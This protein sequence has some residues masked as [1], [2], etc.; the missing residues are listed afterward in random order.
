MIYEPLSEKKGGSAQDLFF[1]NFRS[2]AEFY[3]EKSLE[4]D[5]SHTGRQPV[6]LKNIDSETSEQLSDLR[7][8]FF[9]KRQEYWCICRM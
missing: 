3:G 6:L 9:L 4:K 1:N 5:F 7:R 8:T 2:R